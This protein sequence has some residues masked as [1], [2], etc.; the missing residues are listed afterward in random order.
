MEKRVVERG[1]QKKPVRGTE[2]KKPSGEGTVVSE[3]PVCEQQFPKKK[4]G[5][6]TV[7]SLPAGLKTL[8]L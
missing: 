2:K 6:R 8:Q 4:R 3:C 5:K 1:T 7:S